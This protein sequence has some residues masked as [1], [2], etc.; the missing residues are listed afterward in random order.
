MLLLRPVYNIYNYLSLRRQF[1][2]FNVPYVDNKSK[3][4]EYAGIEN[5]NIIFLN[6]DMTINS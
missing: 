4:P 5:I 1:L 2:L 6:L 3:I